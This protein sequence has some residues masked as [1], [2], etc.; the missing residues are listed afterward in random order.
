MSCTRYRPLISRYVDDEVTPRQRRDLLAHVGACHECAAWLAR[1]RQ[2]DVLL[3]GVP[4]TRPSDRVRNAVLSSVREATHGSIA[5]SASHQKTHIRRPGPRMLASSLLLRF[6]IA[7]RYV[8]LA[9]A[10]ALTLLV[11][12]AYSLSILPPFWGYNKLGFELPGDTEEVNALSTPIQAISE[13]A[14]GQGGPVAAPNIVHVLPGEGAQSIDPQEALRVRF[15]LPMDRTSVEQAWRLDPPAAGNFAWDADNEVRFSPEGQGLLS[16]ITYTVALDSD[17]RS[18]AGTPIE[19]PLLWQFHTREPIGITSDTPAGSSIAPTATLTLLFTSPMAPGA[20]REVSL[21]AA[22]ALTGITLQTQW[23]ERGQKLTLAPTAPLPEGQVSLRI[24]SEAQTQEGEAL[25]RTFEFAYT[26]V[27]SLPRLRLMGERLII[28]PLSQLPALRY[29]AFAGPDRQA[30]QGA[31]F[32]LY[33][34]TAE[35]MAEISSRQFG[36]QSLPPGLVGTLQPAASLNPVSTKGLGDGTLQIEGVAPGLYLLYATAPSGSATLSDWQFVAITD[37]LITYTGEGSPLWATTAEGQ[38]WAGAEILLY[39]AAGSLIESG[40]ADNA[41][42]WQPSTAAVN[43]ALAL[44]RDT[45]GHIAALYLEPAATWAKTESTLAATLRTDNVAYMPGQTINFRMVLHKQHNLTPPTPVAE[46][47]VSL[48]LLSPAE[49]VIATLNLKPDAVGGVNGSF[50]L[51]SSL[52]PG[53]YLVRARAG[54]EQRDFPLIV[55]PRP[56]GSLSIYILPA[57]SVSSV[58]DTPAVT[59]TVS[60]LGPQ[61]EPAVGALV[62]ATLQITGD[63]WTSQSVTAVA[64]RNGRATLTIPLPGWAANFGEPALVL[65]VEASLAERHGSSLQY[66]EDTLPSKLSSGVRQLVSPVLDLAVVARPMP[67]GSVSMRLVDLGMSDTEGAVLILSNTST[68]EKSST[69]VDLSGTGDVTLTLPPG[70]ASATATFFRASTKA[71]RTLQL[72]LLR[73]SDPALK[74]VLPS[75]VQPSSPIPIE[76]TLSNREGVDIEAIASIRFRRVS[77]QA[78]HDDNSGGWEPS[79]TLSA[80]GPATPTLTAPGEPGLWYVIAEAD[81]AG[82]PTVSAWDIITV[83]PGPSVQLPPEQSTTLGRSEQVSVVVHNPD[84]VTLSSGLRVAGTSLVSLLGAQ[85]Q[86]VELG[87]QQ[88]QRV[89]WRY[90]TGKEGLSTLRFSFMPSSGIEGSY[91]LDV[92]AVAEEGPQPGTTYASGVLEGERVVGVQVPSGLSEVG[93]QLQVRASSSLI[94]ALADIATDLMDAPTQHL[95]GAVA[96]ASHLSMVSSVLSAYRDTDSSAPSRLS[97]SPD[98]RSLLLQDIYSAQNTDGSWGADELKAT[99]TS[100]VLLA[101]RRAHLAATGEETQPPLD[102]NVTNRAL[103]YLSWEAGR[104]LPP[105]S[106]TRALDER[107]IMLYTLSLYGNPQPAQ[108]RQLIAYSAENRVGAKLSAAGLAWLAL[109]LWQ[110]GNTEDAL[111]L[112]DR[113][114]LTEPVATPEAAAPLL[115]T[116]LGAGKSAREGEPKAQDAAAYEAAARRYARTLMETRQGIGWAT[117]SLTADAVWVLSRYAAASGEK[118]RRELPM[119]SLNGSPINSPAQGSDSRNGILSVVLMGDTLHAGNNRLTLKAAPNQPMYYSLTLR[120][121]R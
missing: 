19:T 97:L 27:P 74:M 67:D 121:V 104:A 82:G 109:A 42:L 85:Y 86:S 12:A 7:P 25:G 43:S 8:V 79:I 28:A 115:E 13:G 40:S 30:L 89:T 120:A 50:R 57:A 1:A 107:A 14:F 56:S 64:D 39:S 44:A 34:L 102:S 48:L 119:L 108:T 38:A 81:T 117:P 106:T 37:R 112:L 72:M 69:A 95:E 92:R 118:P 59:R 47:E 18:M 16:G 66:I 26:V 96:S 29:E 65:G 5:S 88:W 17:A 3:K 98:Q 54:G 22:G 9:T 15:D 60:I 41:G 103:A 23:D 114:L 4:E 105:E 78:A 111:A 84:A 45:E 51:A 35:R 10:G 76:L 68:G 87:A 6:D 91:A 93:V 101:L 83:K 80:T 90:R 2:T 20:A 113:I 21:R 24:G 70:F 75:T 63:T 53:K 94:P 77:G 73:G 62:T 99:M 33:A 116:L 46:Q 61:G 58:N 49:A 31:S 71:S 36:Q 55:Q 52:A 32:Q 110:S 11:F 100:Q